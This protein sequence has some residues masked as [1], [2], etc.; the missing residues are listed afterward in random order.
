M[1]EFRSGRLGAALSW[2]L[3]AKDAAFAAFLAEKSVTVHIALHSLVSA[4]HYMAQ[5]SLLHSLVLFRYFASYQSLGEFMDLDLLDHL[6]SAMLLSE[7]LAFL[8]E[9]VCV[10]GVSCDYHVINGPRQVPGVSSA[11]RGGT[12]LC[13]WTSAR[14]SS[15]VWH[16]SKEVNN[17]HTHT[18]TT[19]VLLHTDFG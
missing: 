7:K 9:V 12:V 14:V 17:A 13:R 4:V 3:Q 15:A 6:G 5:C 11:L 16:C 2:C 10:V 1:R 8:G 19:H 18:H